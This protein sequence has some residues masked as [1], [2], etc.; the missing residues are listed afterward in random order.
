M[1][2]LQL[3]QITDYAYLH[4]VMITSDMVIERLQD[5][6][7]W[8]YCYQHSQSASVER[9]ADSSGQ[10]LRD[11]YDDDQYIN[12]RSVLELFR[13]GSTLVISGVQYLFPDLRSLSEK[14][15]LTL[16]IAEVPA[17]LY[18]G[19]RTHSPSYPY[20]CHD[21]D[22]LVKNIQGS[23]TW[24]IEDQ[25][26]VLDQQNVFFIGRDRYH[27]CEQVHDE[28]LTVTFDFYPADK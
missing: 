13:Q 4:P 24:L 28:K 27:C 5:R 7:R 15:A 16:G 9:I 17:V 2:D 21:H 6:Y 11:F 23:S 3:K 12:S 18:M 22:V 8:P 1:D 19:C 25:R 26:Y 10:L 20:H 14:F